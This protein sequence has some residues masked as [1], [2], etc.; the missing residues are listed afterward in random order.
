MKFKTILA[1][2]AA[3]ALAGA[4]GA[5]SAA[6]LWDFQSASI[7]GHTNGDWDFGNQFSINTSIQINQLGYYDDNGDGFLSDHSVSLYD[8]SGNL[9]ASATVDNTGTLL[10]NFRYVKIKAVNLAVGTYQIH[11]N[12]GRDNYTWNNNA[13][14]SNVNYLGN[15]W[16]LTG[17][18]SFQSCCI[19]D[20]ADGY[21]GA[22][23]NYA[24]V[25]E[26]ATWAMMIAGFGIAGGALRRRRAVATA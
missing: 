16:Q 21:W 8:L 19:N 7:A 9:L 5:A 3:I 17:D 10:G 24:A 20:V 6:P 13:F 23:A 11:G 4:A 26:P 14:V 25:P 1:A 12:S 22:N 2:T 18:S 15:T